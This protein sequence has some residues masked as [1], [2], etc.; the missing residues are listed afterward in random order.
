MRNGWSAPRKLKHTLRKTEKTYENLSYDML[1][2]IP[3]LSHLPLN[4]LLIEG[5]II[6]Q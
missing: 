6:K 2:P 5:K 4:F 1:P 3:V